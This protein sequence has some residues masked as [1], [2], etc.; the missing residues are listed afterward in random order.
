MKTT[1]LIKVAAQS[2]I[3]NKMRTVL[4]MLGI[5]IGVAAVIVMVAVGYGA[6][7]RIAE[8]IQNLGTN[9]II[10]TPGSSAQGGVSQGAQTFNRLRVEDAEALVRETHAAV[11]G[12][13]GGDDAHAGDRRRGQLAHVGARRVAPL[14]GDPRLADLVRRVLERGRRALDAARRRA[15]RDRRQR[16]LSRGRSGRLADPGARRAVHRHRRAGRQG[17]DPRRVGSGRRRAGALH[18]RAD[19]ALGLELRRPDPRQR[20]LGVG[21]PDRE[22]RDARDPARG[23]QAG[24][25][26]SSTT[27]RSAP[28]TRSPKRRRA[29][30]R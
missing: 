20:L 14:S 28:R 12:V 11:V 22:G 27:S 16:A 10:V 29:R 23:A 26:R 9:M 13:A 2:I 19:A 6:R 7:T 5:V 1:R 25:R 15:R 24:R 18:H 21:H 17:P 4:T 8:Q 30:P 3:K